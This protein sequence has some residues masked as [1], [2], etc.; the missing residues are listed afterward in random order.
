[1]HRV[2]EVEDDPVRSVQ[3][4]I[5]EILRLAARNIKTRTSHAIASSRLVK[6]ELVGKNACSL[7]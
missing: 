7:S 4:S 3:C 1:M 2:L 5:D 6:R